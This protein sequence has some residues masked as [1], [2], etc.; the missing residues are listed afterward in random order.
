[1]ILTVVFAGQQL[2]KNANGQNSFEI[3]FTIFET[4]GPILPLAFYLPLKI[5]KRFHCL[6]YCFIFWLGEILI[7]ITP[8]LPCMEAWHEAVIQIHTVNLINIRLGESG[9]PFLTSY[10]YYKD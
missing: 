1:M 7:I 9:S 10:E 2:S 8:P 3:N 6:V 5:V 4:N